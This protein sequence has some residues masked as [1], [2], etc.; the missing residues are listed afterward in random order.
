MTSIR[1]V[2]A[3]AAALGAAVSAYAQNG[4]ET[5]IFAGG[6]FWSLQ[7][8]F[9][10][11]YGVIEAASGYTGGTA[12][13]PT[14]KTYASGGHAQAVRVV[15]D[16]SRVGYPELLNVFW[17]NTDPTDAGGQFSDRGPGFRTAI[18]WLS[19]SQR[20]QAEES[21]AALVRSGRFDTPVVT[22]IRKAGSFTVA[23]D[24]QQEY[25]MRNP[26]D[27]QSYRAASGRDTYFARVWGPAA[28]RDPAA[29]PSARDGKYV[30]PS[31]EQL[32]KTLSPLVYHV[33]QEQGTEAPFNNPYWNNHRE[34]I[35]VDVVSGEP[36]FSSRDKFES[37]TGW[38]SFTMPLEPANVLSSVDRGFGMVRTEVHSRFAGSHLGHVFDDGPAPTGLRYCMDSASLRFVPVEDLQKEGYGQYLP[39]FRK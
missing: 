4:L 8:S 39:L 11:V 28:L 23:E 13:R 38:P 25:A 21:K 10:K 26:A 34:G 33:T 6:S 27:Y 1:I 35:Y 2:L 17:R 12:A 14:Y 29:P 24:A 5:A 32:R 3:A 7:E 36:L 22:E 31:A 30:K 37:G 18:Y 9:Q 15:F 20:A 19:D 16:P